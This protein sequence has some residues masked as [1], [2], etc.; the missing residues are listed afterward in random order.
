MKDRV[1]V[2][3]TLGVTSIY[4]YLVID[5]KANVEGFVVL[6]TYII[7]KALDLIEKNGGG[8]NNE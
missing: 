6:S 8:Q 3:I 2:I 7:K 5:G 4:L 1:Q